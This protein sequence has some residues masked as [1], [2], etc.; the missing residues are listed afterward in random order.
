MRSVPLPVAAAVMMSATAA[1]ADNKSDCQKGVAMIK[2]KLKKKHPAPVLVTLCKALSD[3]ETEVIEKDWS[4][5]TDHI[6]TARAAQQVSATPKRVVSIVI[7]RSAPRLPLALEVPPSLPARAGEV[8]ALVCSSC[9][10]STSAVDGR[11]D[12]TNAALPRANGARLGVC[13][14]RC[15]KLERLGQQCGNEAMYSAWKGFVG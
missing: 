9:V 11:S 10:R 8:I 4:E 12:V 5:C 3:A 6:K 2:A 1:L 14:S 13:G 15:N 7:G